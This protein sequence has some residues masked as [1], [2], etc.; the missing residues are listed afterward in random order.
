MTCL[1]LYT[2]SHKCCNSDMQTFGIFALRDIK[3]NE[4]VVLAWE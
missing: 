2:Q 1:V 4:E 3:V